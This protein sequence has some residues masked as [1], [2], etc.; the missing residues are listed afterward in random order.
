[1]AVY[2]EILKQNALLADGESATSCEVRWKTFAVLGNVFDLELPRI[3]CRFLDFPPKKADLSGDLWI[4]GIGCRFANKDS[5]SPKFCIESADFPV[6]LHVDWRL[7]NKDS[8]R[9]EDPEPGQ[10]IRGTNFIGEGGF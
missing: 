3:S 10:S 2:P 9:L 6:F 5:A 4:S 8:L 7:T 1:L